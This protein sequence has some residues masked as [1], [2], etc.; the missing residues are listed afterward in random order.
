MG[1]RTHGAIS[2]RT[3]AAQLRCRDVVV[4]YVPR[5]VRMRTEQVE[6]MVSARREDGRLQ[7]QTG[8]LWLR[9]V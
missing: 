6:S 7:A 3:G 8:C 5:A 9:K 1:P 2:S 4:F